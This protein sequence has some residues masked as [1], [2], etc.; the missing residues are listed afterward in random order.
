MWR[1]EE[2]QSSVVSRLKTGGRVGSFFTRHFMQ[3]TIDMLSQRVADGGDEGDGGDGGDG[4]DDI[5]GDDR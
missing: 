5:E 3:T 1:E 2:F 4:Y